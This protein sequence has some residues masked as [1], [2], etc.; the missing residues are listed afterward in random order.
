MRMMMMPTRVSSTAQASSGIVGFKSRL[1]LP[2]LKSVGFADRNWRI[3]GVLERQG[4]FKR[5]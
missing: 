5:N 3:Y 4:G 1:R 2:E